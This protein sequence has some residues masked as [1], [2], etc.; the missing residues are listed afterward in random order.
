MKYV[1]SRKGL[2]TAVASILGTMW[3]RGTTLAE[4]QPVR[5]RGLVG[6]VK[7][8]LP[9]WGTEGGWRIVLGDDWPASLTINQRQTGFL[10]KCVKTEVGL[11]RLFV[12]TALN[13][14]ARQCFF[15]PGIRG[16]S[17]VCPVGKPTHSDF[18]KSVNGKILNK[19]QNRYSFRSL[20]Q[21]RREIN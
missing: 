17:W 9:L 11:I 18:V 10:I 16:M 7:C 6:P 21:T 12:T 5:L 20:D 15:E 14:P 2:S 19:C 4:E 8:C 13:L 1:L 3:C